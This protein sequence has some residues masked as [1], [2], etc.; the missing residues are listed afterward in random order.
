M[1]RTS[2]YLGLIC[3]SA[4][5]FHSAGVTG[6]VVD[7][8]KLSTYS[9][10]ATNPTR[11]DA[12]YTAN[13]ALTTASGESTYP[14]TT[15]LTTAPVS[16]PLGKPIGYTDGLP[17]ASS[18]DVTS[19]INGLISIMRGLHSSTSSSTGPAL[20]GHATTLITSHSSTAT[21]STSA[22]KP[23]QSTPLCQPAGGPTVDTDYAVAL[24]LL[25]AGL[26]GNASGNPISP[27]GN[28]LEKTTA[29]KIS[30]ENYNF[31]SYRQTPPDPQ[32]SSD[33]VRITG[34]INW[35]DSCTGSATIDNDKCI[36]YMKS[37][38]TTCRD[39]SE[40]S[41]TLPSETGG[42][43]RVRRSLN[44]FSS[45]PFMGGAITGEKCVAYSLSVTP[46]KD[47]RPVQKRPAPAE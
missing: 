26:C 20:T 6:E 28:S 11:T 19:A 35:E 32:N 39:L 40:D 21:T 18:S 5:V 14:T 1:P 41:S 23:P 24:N 3:S 44:P 43:R 33:G 16:Y 27:A 38:L 17:V 7:T 47:G 25:V 45:G 4:F 10:T 30:A 31:T 34:S 29:F 22:T 36:G 42:T 2:S 46:A 9:T 13:T 8:S 15:P 37:V 12:T